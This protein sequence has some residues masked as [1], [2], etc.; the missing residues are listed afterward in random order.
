VW[1]I[2][3]GEV[4]TACQVECCENQLD[5]FGRNPPL[6]ALSA[7]LSELPESDGTMSG[8][9]VGPPEGSEADRSDHDDLPF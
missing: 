6:I 9:G 7:D 5:L 1:T 8:R 4:W 3:Q 2:H